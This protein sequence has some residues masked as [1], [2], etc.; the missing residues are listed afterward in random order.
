MKPVP[1]A[2]AVAL[3]LALACDISFGPGAPGDQANGRSVHD[4]GGPVAT[5]SEPC[6]SYNSYSQYFARL[7]ECDEVV[8]VYV[9]T[10]SAAFRDSVQI[11]AQGWK[12]AFPAGYRVPRFGVVSTA[13]PGPANI[14][15]TVTVKILGDATGDEWCGGGSSQ[16]TRELYRIAA[17][18]TCPLNYPGTLTV[19]TMIRLARHELGHG[20][21]YGGQHLNNLGT[22][23][24]ASCVM[25]VA[26]GFNATPCG[27][28]KQLMYWVYA[29][30]STLPDLAT[31]SNVAVVLSPPSATIEQGATQ[32]FTA[33]L[34][35]GE[36][37]P[38]PELNWTISDLQIAAFAA[39]PT[40]TAILQGGAVGQTVLTAT[41]VESPSTNWPTSSGSAT[42]TVQAPPPPPPPPVESVTID[43]NG[44]TLVG[45]TDLTLTATA[46]DAQGNVIPNVTFTWSVRDTAIIY[47]VPQG[48]SAWIS[49]KKNGTTQV[50]AS[51]PNGVTARITVIVQGCPVRCYA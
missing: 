20:L 15:R 33:N 44:V 36:N 2:V 40:T 23:N 39:S 9:Q 17:G 6:P 8:Y 18:R 31:V 12:D 42:L 19:R 13:P 51:A 43:P 34:Y 35:G 27:P 30:R 29:L 11:A 37:S 5:T 28:E 22:S 16:T 47:F 14:N 32:Q 7:W 48:G 10:S 21:G 3:G 24:T 50:F 1:V 46:R 26:G 4:I 45:P 49:A 41:V 25:H 38:T